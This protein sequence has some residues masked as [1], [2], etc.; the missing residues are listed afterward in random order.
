MRPSKRRIF[1]VVVVVVVDCFLI[2]VVFALSL[3]HT[4]ANQTCAQER[5]D[6]HR[7]VQLHSLHDMY[8]NEITPKSSCLHY[9]PLLQV[10]KMDCSQCLVFPYK[11]LCIIMSR[12]VDVDDV[13]FILTCLLVEPPAP[14]IVHEDPYVITSCHLLHI[15]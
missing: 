11:F 10:S 12:F 8:E 14:Q 1:V 7:F 13:L 6:L 9:R 3:C 4:S 2:G 5:I 15:S